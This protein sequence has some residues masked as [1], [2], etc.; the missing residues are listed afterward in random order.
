MKNIFLATIVFALCNSGAIF[1]QNDF[2]EYSVEVYDEDAEL[3]KANNLLIPS[4]DTIERNFM[5]VITFPAID[6]SVTP[7]SSIENQAKD[8][9]NERNIESI[10]VKVGSSSGSGDYFSGSFS[11]KDWANIPEGSYYGINGNKHYIKV[12]LKN[13]TKVSVKNYSVQLKNKSGALSTMRS[14]AITK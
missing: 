9:A 13:I 10:Q 11:P 14:G 12:P 4:E 7:G 1:S 6:T 5:F 3:K 8:G 2:P